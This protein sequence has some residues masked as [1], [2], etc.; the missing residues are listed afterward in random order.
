MGRFYKTAKPEMIDFM[1]KVPEQAIMTA[2]KGADAQIE[3][4]EAYLTDL[5]KQ[6][7]TAALEPDEAKRKQRVSELEGKIREHSLKI[8]ENPLLAIKEQKGIRDLG[9]EIYK[10]LTEGELYAYNTNYAARQEYYKKAVEDATGKDGRLNVGQVNNAMAAYDAMYKMKEGAKFDKTTG[11]FNPY[12]TELLYDYVDKSEY[13]KKTAEGWESKKTE[14]L[15]SEPRGAYW[16]EIGKKTDVL[17]LDELTLG[18]HNT[19]LNDP[20]V[21]QQVTQDIQLKAQAKAAQEVMTSG[22]DYKTLYD[23]YFNEFRDEE[24]GVYDP[25]T[26]QL[27]IREVKDENGKPKINEQTGKP[28]MEFVN[29]GNLYRISQAAADKKNKEDITTTEKMTGADPFSLKAEDL[30]NAKALEDY[31]NLKTVWDQE[32]DEFTETM[33]AG[34]NAEEVE[35]EFKLNESQLNDEAQTYKKKLLTILSTGKTEGQIKT[36]D[37]SLQAYIKPDGTID[38]SGLKTFMADNGVGGGRAD[39]TSVDEFEK[40]YNKAKIDLE[41]KKTVYNSLYNNAEEN[42]SPIDK[43]FYLSNKQV[44]AAIDDKIKSKRLELEAAKKSNPFS[45]K[46]E[47]YESEL[48][49]LEKEKNSYVSANKKIISRTLKLDAAVPGN[50]NI[51]T[52]SSLQ[53]AGDLY[54]SF[55]ATEEETNKV[56]KALDDLGAEDLYSLLGAATQTQVRSTNNMSMVNFNGTTLSKYFKDKDTYAISYDD[57]GNITAKTKRDGKVV[58]KGKVGKYRVAIDD[59]DKVGANSIST[60]ISATEMGPDGKER[61]VNYSIYIPSKELKNTTVSEIQSKYQNESEFLAFTRRAE[62]MVTNTT[63][64]TISIKYN[65]EI[66]YYPNHKGKGKGM[67]VFLTSDPKNPI[68]TEN[69][70]EA[71]KLFKKY[72]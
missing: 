40:N 54:K 52:K 41:N 5:Q 56:Q 9:Q 13:A 63:D 20:T 26:K 67:F 59:F 47:D 39:L 45:S 22:G 37:K 28:I 29:P 30:K 48:Q 71:M 1:F 36:I 25:D 31:K 3:G 11:K 38:F 33:F 51:I 2:I 10:D 7:K 18:I 58:F 17:G 70:T 24:F 69:S 6:L 44:A 35:A 57:Q 64:P 23:K 19:M 42:L 61:D 34:K 12:G 66:V 62:G 15:R 46:A 21:V 72:K 50:N 4:Q 8:W 68:S 16:W 14:T 55:G 60:N 43:V 53:T 65:D 27:A 49:A 32:T